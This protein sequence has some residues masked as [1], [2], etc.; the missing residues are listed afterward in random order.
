M[1][2]GPHQVALITKHLFTHLL[3]FL[4]QFGIKTLLTASSSL[5]IYENINDQAII[6]WKKIIA[7]LHYN[8]RGTEQ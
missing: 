6:Q 3:T 4:N 8:F 2:Y 1:S 7:H 5:L